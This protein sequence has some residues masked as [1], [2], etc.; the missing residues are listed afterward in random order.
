M[1]KLLDDAKHVDDDDDDDGVV[2][3]DINDGYDDDDDSRKIFLSRIP[4]SFNEAII[5]RIFEAK[6]GVDCVVNVSIVYDKQKMNDYENGG[7]ND[8]DKKKIKFGMKNDDEQL[9]HRGFAFVTFTSTDKCQEAILAGTVRGSA[10]MNTNT[11]TTTATSKRKHTM[12]IRPVLRD[13]DTSNHATKHNHTRNKD[14]KDG[15]N[16]KDICFLWKKHRCP[17]GE[18]CKFVH[19][20]EGG[21]VVTT[22][23]HVKND[24]DGNG[25]TTGT[26]SKK[27]PCFNFKKSGKC[28]AGDDCPFLHDINVTTT[29]TKHKEEEGAEFGK[30]MDKSQIMCINWKNKGKCRKGEK[31]PY[32]HGNNDDS[33]RGTVVV[34][35]EEGKDTNEDID[36]EVHT[37]D[38]KEKK[39]KR[40]ENKQR[41]SL[42][43]RIFGLNY[44]TTPD[45]VR[46]LLQHC[47]PI[48]E[49]TFP[50]FEDSGRSKGY[51]GV[52]FQSPKA[53]EKAILLDGCELHDRW[54]R[55]Q[56]GR[57]FL[58]KWEE[59]ENDRR[60][61]QG[62]GTNDDDEAEEKDGRNAMMD[63]KEK[64][65][66]GEFGQRVKKRKKHGYKD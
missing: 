4:Q 27:K 36:D 29:T 64:I 18:G 46:T 54:L 30:Q 63:A 37:T 45:D 22:T 49:L 44:N 33:I 5:T 11:S 25:G 12:Y 60:K 7:G 55:I 13:D 10:K 39:R 50:T 61:E 8:T 32:R 65:V 40:K 58:K 34:G 52:L 48:M 23:P 17:Y 26:S 47:G 20:G 15:N 21:C 42:S 56:E 6:F 28:K 16:S 53:V 59:V 24:G 19:V 35:R 51:C 31:C 2:D 43:I 57:M 41:Q 3:D 1:D 66:L 62:W 14:S 9:H 38:T